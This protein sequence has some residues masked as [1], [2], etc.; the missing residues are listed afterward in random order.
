MDRKY[1]LSAT[2]G[3]DQSPACYVSECSPFLM[4][5]CIYCRSLTGLR[6]VAVLCRSGSRA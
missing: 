5:F 4:A 2:A 6:Y 3:S 1:L